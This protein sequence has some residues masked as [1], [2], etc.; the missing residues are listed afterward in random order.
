M[1]HIFFEVILQKFPYSDRSDSDH[2][3]FPINLF[4]YTNRSNNI[5][6]T[7]CNS[8]NNELHIRD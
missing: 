6:K 1:Y 7:I 5:V 3:F 8:H 2:I 4:I